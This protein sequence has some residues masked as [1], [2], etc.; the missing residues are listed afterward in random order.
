[1]FTLPPFVGREVYVIGYGEVGKMYN[2][3]LGAPKL[4]G[5]GAAGLLADTALGPM[6]IGGSVGDTGHSKWFFQLGRVF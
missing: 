5:D 1:M 6:F 2:D 3:P 4:S